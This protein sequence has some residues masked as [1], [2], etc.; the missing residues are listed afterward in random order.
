MPPPLALLGGVV[1]RTMQGVFVQA[2]G[3]CPVACVDVVAAAAAAAVVA[4]AVDAAVAATTVA[5]ATSSPVRTRGSSRATRSSWPTDCQ[6]TTVA[7]RVQ[8]IA[9]THQRSLM[10]RPTAPSLGAIVARLGRRLHHQQ[11]PNDSR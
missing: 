11:P 5:A 1:A 2:S 9:A 8:A 4:T 10:N 3:S 6:Q 7:R